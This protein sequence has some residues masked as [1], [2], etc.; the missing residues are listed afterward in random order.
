MHWT[1]LLGLVGGILLVALAG[2]LI[3]QDRLRKLRAAQEAE[4]L[5]F[6]HE[7]LRA[8][9]GGRPPGEPTP[10]D[11][12]AQAQG[13]EP[14]VGDVGGADRTPAPA[15]VSGAPGSPAAEGCFSDGVI[16]KLR[17]AGLVTRVEG[18]IAGFPGVGVELRDGTRLGILDQPL[19][20]SAPEWEPLLRRFG[21]LI[22]PGPGAEPVY[23]RRFQALINDLI[24]L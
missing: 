19:P 17:A 21:G 12:V 2:I 13:A 10:P 7:V 23:I 1:L 20:V 22:T 6:E 18:P 9:G 24:R 8:I 11:K 5:V 14:S 3:A 15:D 4:A 16:E